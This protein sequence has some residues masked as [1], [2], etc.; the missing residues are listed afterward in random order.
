MTEDELKANAEAREK[1]RQEQRVRAAELQVELARIRVLIQPLFP[2]V[3]GDEARA[4]ACV[5]T[6]IDEAALWLSVYQRSGQV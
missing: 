4:V 6:K 2:N 5:R 3:S 1:Q